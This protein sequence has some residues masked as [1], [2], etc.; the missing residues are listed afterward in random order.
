MSHRDRK[1]PNDFSQ[2]MRGEGTAGFGA[3]TRS[4]A[5]KIGVKAPPAAMPPGNNRP[6]SG[7][8]PV[9]PG[10][11]IPCHLG[12]RI[13]T[14]LAI[15]SLGMLIVGAMGAYLSNDSQR[16]A[17]TT[18]SESVA[19]AGPLVSPDTRYSELERRLTQINDLH[20]ERLHSLETKLA[21]TI[22]PYEARLKNVESRL[23]TTVDPGA[24]RLQ[25][26]ENRLEQ[27]NAL[28]YEARLTTLE[29]RLE[30]AYAPY[31]AGLQDMESRWGQGF[32]GYDARLQE[33]ENR[34]MQIQIPYE[35]R[36]QELEQRLI[37]AS[38]RLDY[39]SAE[40]E[41]FSKDHTAI[42]E[43]NAT[44]RADP[45]AA[46]PVEA[47]PEAPV[48]GGAPPWLPPA[49]AAENATMQTTAWQMDTG[50]GG[51]VAPAAEMP[52]NGAKSP[53]ASPAPADAVQD[54]PRI[55]E[56]TAGIT[57]V[58]G[59]GEEI[60]PAPPTVIDHAEAPAAQ[61]KPIEPAPEIRQDSLPSQTRMGDWVINLASYA[62]ESI[63]AR[64]LADFERKGVTAE[65]VA[66]TVNGKTI[67]RVRIA[68]FDTRK[69]ATARAE[70]IRRQLG[71][72]ETWVTRQ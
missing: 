65:Q 62:S 10:K 31:Q 4:D 27:F 33:L 55:D 21:Q 34:L 40:M 2:K 14:G 71:L 41:S 44:L 7:T 8:H 1:E 12:D 70:A 3:G 59:A 37:Y 9:P 68:G 18:R 52:P 47:A 39:L 54:K 61:E 53:A 38:A 42:I 60:V 19:S 28:N 25:A 49:A 63:A 45:P 72:A 69:A 43:A 15:M 23:E 32:V 30:Q 66:A 22:D 67:Y 51:P 35:Q 57:D 6:R 50:S 48:D 36:L 24:S 13:L 26:L 11:H 56:P 58:A 64:K 29:N 5:A 17:T 16:V 46:M 20:G